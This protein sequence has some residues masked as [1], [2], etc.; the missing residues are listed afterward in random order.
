MPLIN[1]IQ[2]TFAGGEYSPSIY[3][4]VDIEKYRTGLKKCRNFYVHPHGGASNRP[5]TKYIADCGSHNTVSVLRSFV[6]S[7]TQAYILEFGVNFVRF[8]ENQAVIPRAS[9][10][11]SDWLTGNAYVVD[12]YV[13]YNTSS[14]LCIDPDGTTGEPPDAFPAVWV[15]QTTYQIYSPYAEADLLDL[16]LESSADTIYI[17]HPDYQTRTLSRYDTADWRFA[18]Y[19]PQNGP[20]M[21]QNLTATTLTP[22][23]V[24]GVCTVTATT[25]GT[26][27]STHVGALFK[28][29]HYVEGSTATTAF[30]SATTG[31]AIGC[32]TTW[33]L[34]THGT[35]TGNLKIEKSIDGGS[36]W[37]ALR[38]FSSADDFNVNTS[39]T[40]DIETNTDPFQVRLNMYAYTSGT[41]NADLTSDAYYH[42][43]IIDITTYNTSS[44]VT[45][46]VLSDFGGTG[47]VTEWSEGSWS[48]KR[49]WPSVSRFY[50]DRLCFAGS[51]S[52][53]MTIWMTE[54]A[55][56]TSFL[57]HSTLIDSD[58]ITVNLP[59]RQLNA[60]NGLTALK[61]LIAVTS[62]SEWTVGT[63]S[64]AALSPLSIET[65]VEGYRGSNG[66]NPQL[67]GNEAI[68]IQSAGKVVRNLGYS[69]EADSFTGAELNILSKHLFDKWNIVDMAYQQDPDSI[70]WCL[71]DDGILLGMTYM[72]EQE[73][74][75]W[76]WVDTG[77]VASNDVASIESVATIPGD[78]YDELWISVQR[79]DYRFVEVMTKRIVEAECITGGKK[80]LSENAFFV[81]SGVSYGST[82]TYITSIVLSTPVV[83]NALAHGFSNGD[84]IRLDNIVDYETLNATTWVI[85]S[86]LTNSFELSSQ[87]V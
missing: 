86:V 17:T 2:P 32:F 42:D 3:P 11:S 28:L 16:R 49:G 79:G 82:P 55:N 4:R 14:Y 21:V 75:A 1:P 24:T 26:F 38:T 48:D 51:D 52:E 78:G 30:S 65:Q 25:A 33:R 31:T 9:S 80:Y 10:D 43:G 64:G 5:G 76:F 20:F 84:Y 61:K 74:V 40:E 13:T 18:L 6:F 83:V 35:W 46:T 87:V 39:G 53:P 8:F 47:A 59:S 15:A 57:R 85:G 73:V 58:G 70:V 62:S 12:D 69:F 50:Q 19:A 41:C 27:S 7:Q 60:I 37:T 36:T 71:R 54:T 68:F 45:G 34:V 29:R 63:A 81:D 22:S 56:Y 44:S 67:I 72:K 66:V 77:T 23:V